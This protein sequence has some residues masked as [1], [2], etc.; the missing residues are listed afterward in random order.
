MNIRLTRLFQLRH[1][2]IALLL[3]LILLGLHSFTST[4]QPSATV[5][6]QKMSTISITQAGFLPNQLSKRVGEKI[7][8]M[9]VNQDT[10]PHNFS[11]VKLHVHSATLKPGE[12][13]SLILEESLHKGVY[14]FISNPSGIPET[15]Y[16]G[17]L[18]IE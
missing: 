13:T 14:P 9:V 3:I 18:S 8:L 11:I 2:L 7:T 10:R 17:Q 6:Q 16:S 12:S 1:P 5:L 15:G 4:N